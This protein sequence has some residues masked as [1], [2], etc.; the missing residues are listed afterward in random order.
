[1]S[2][3]ARSEGGVVALASVRVPRRARHAF[4]HER[5]RRLAGFPVSLAQTTEVS[6]R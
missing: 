2:G 1:M 6:C 5:A 4:W 3:D